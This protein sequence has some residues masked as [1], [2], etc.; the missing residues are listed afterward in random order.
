[1]ENKKTG[2]FYTPV[3]LIK[4]MVK[5]A[6]DYMDIKSVLE[7]SIGDGRFIDELLNYN[8]KITGV[9]LYEDKI[10]N[11]DRH[12]AKLSLICSDFISYAL[13]NGKTYDLIIGNP[14]YIAKKQLPKDVWEK[15]YAINT[16]FD[17]PTSLF[18]N[19]WVSFVLASIKLLKEGG[20]LFFVLPFEFL[21]VQYANKL[22]NFLEKE[23]NFIEITT[24]EE[25]VF[26]EIEQD[27]C[28]LYLTN[29]KDITPIIKYKTFNN[30]AEC[31]LLSHSEICRHKPLQKWS[32]SILNDDE[33]SF[34]LD[35]S[36]KYIK[37]SELGYISPGIVTGA[38]DFFIISEDK[39]KQLSCED[40]SIPI[41]SKS[42]STSNLLIFNSSDMK[43]L[44]AQGKPTRLL[45]LSSRDE[46]DFSTAL[47]LYLNNDID[48]NNLPISQRYKCG[49]RKRWY[50]VPIISRGDLI[51]FKR[52]DI[53]PKLLVNKAEVYTTDITYNIR[54]SD[55][56][57]P[58]SVAFSFYNS[59][60]LALCE[61]NGRFYGGGVN[62]LVPSEFKSLSIPYQK[63]DKVDV[64]KLDK[65][66]RNNESIESIIDFV[67]SIV[68]KS[69][70]KKDI[71][72]LKEIRNKYLK[73][74]LKSFR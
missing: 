50:D 29:Q 65:M 61:Y 1:M 31:R 43:K 25:K 45:N 35:L 71:K 58:L 9:E 37:I 63:I 28:L 48:K 55:Q 62:E 11:Y 33:T 52:F 7:P 57:D 53:L 41:V 5:Q 16:H 59:L 2:S 23:F 26:P 30:I 69:I 6:F 74:R 60:T 39:S 19:I 40:A 54:L 8:V 21:Q 38:N 3:P 68:F 47:L 66:F 56:Y 12:D 27:I 72:K 64:V 70:K 18:Q 34:L 46:K 32:N 73:R 14:P 4:Y 49:K 22:R 67:D 15:Q 42:S 24:F 36:G 17:L 51:F 13:D 44:E 20:A 10:K